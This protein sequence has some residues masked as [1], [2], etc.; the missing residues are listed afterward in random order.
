MGGS[1]SH[2]RRPGVLVNSNLSSRP[3]LTPNGLRAGVATAASRPLSGR[4][5][6]ELLPTDRLTSFPVRHHVEKIMTGR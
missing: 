4:S 6:A 1:A 5:H 3:E 2:L